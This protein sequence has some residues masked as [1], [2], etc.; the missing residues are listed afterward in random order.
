MAVTSRNHG[1]FVTGPNGTPPLTVVFAISVASLTANTVLAPS[2]P[3]ILNDLS[4]STQWAGVIVGA[5][6][7]PGIVFSPIFGVL[8]DRH[9]KRLIVTAALTIF[10]LM[11]LPVA[12][13]PNGWL[14]LAARVGQGIG[15]STLVGIAVAIIADFW[16]GEQ[17]AKLIGWNSA[18][19]TT[20]V[21]V[22]PLLGGLT[23]D[24]T[25]WRWA[26]GLQTIA[27]PVALWV[28]FQLPDQTADH[29]RHNGR[30]QSNPT[31]A[32]RF[33]K[34]AGTAT[35]KAVRPI[36]VAG[37]VA[38]FLI[39]GVFLTVMPLY[40]QSE[41]GLQ[42]TA[43]SVVI[44]LPGVFA[45]LGALSVNVIRRRI[46][47]AWLV[48]ASGLAVF[49][50]AFAGLSVAPVLAI[51]IAA[52]TLYGVAE[53]FTIPT[54]QEAAVNAAPPEERATYVA[55]FV[56]AAR[57]G[58]TAGPVAIATVASVGGA[59]FSLAVAALIAVMTVSY[60]FVRRGVFQ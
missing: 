16:D 10:G 6:A 21:A 46:K 47:G 26:A 3:E 7:L 39:F 4:L 2:L 35:Q 40:L 27:L 19:I 55:L 52:V 28:W 29:D 22:F 51:A 59:R 60:F 58:Q 9:G 13:A 42:T 8:A 54:M 31:I 49:A 43:R 23:A 41:F 17:R 18:V 36:F 53:G 1:W 37:F 32:D 33:S 34:L 5:G 44:A 45:I 48:L 30:D 25:S 20:C 12:L 38:F 50:I 11:A 24:L 14:L 15:A 57:A 56:S